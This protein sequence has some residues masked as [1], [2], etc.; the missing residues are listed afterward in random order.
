MGVFNIT[1]IVQFVLAGCKMIIANLVLR[2]PLAIYH[3]ISSVRLWN[4]C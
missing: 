1:T 4:N 2:V 3:L